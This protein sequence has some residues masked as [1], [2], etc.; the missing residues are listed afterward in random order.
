ML[1]DN[2]PKNLNVFQVGGKLVV[3]DN[4]PFG[5][6]KSLNPLL[7]DFRVFLLETVGEPE[8]HNWEAFYIVL[9]QCATTSENAV[10]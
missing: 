1:P 6:Q 10:I 8:C 5:S 2:D 3:G 4:P 7:L 9:W